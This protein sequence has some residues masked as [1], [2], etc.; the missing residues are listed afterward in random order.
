MFGAIITILV[1]YFLVAIKET[2]ET[3]RVKE[4][5]NAELIK[6]KKKIEK[7][8]SKISKSKLNTLADDL[9]DI[10]KEIKQ[11]PFLFFG[12]EILKNKF[13]VLRIDADYFIDTIIIYLDLKDIDSYIHSFPGMVDRDQAV[14]IKIKRELISKIEFCNIKIRKKID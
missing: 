9:I 11:N 10:K 7:I 3:K 8:K 13:S 4:I 2:R 14:I 6:N 5:I 12:K 1:E